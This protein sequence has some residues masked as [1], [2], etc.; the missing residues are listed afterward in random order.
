MRVGRSV[1]KLSGFVQEHENFID[2]AVCFAGG[3]VYAG[4]KVGSIRGQAELHNIEWVWRD[5]QRARD[6]RSQGDQIDQ[7]K[8]LSWLPHSYDEDC[9]RV[10]QSSRDGGRVKVEAAKHTEEG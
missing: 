6:D 5:L 10:R 9:K 1:H 4:A 2:V 7:M 8:Q 3:L